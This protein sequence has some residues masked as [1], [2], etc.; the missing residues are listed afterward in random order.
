MKYNPKVKMSEVFHTIQ[1][2]GRF[3]GT[4]SIFVR[5]SLC[6]LRCRWCDTPYTSW[7]PEFELTTVDDVVEQV[8]NIAPKCRHVVIT[9]GEPFAQKKALQWLCDRLQREQY[10]VTIETAAIVWQYLYCSLL[11]MSPKL[12]TST[13][14]GTPQEKNH[15]KHRLNHD[16]I[17]QML[18]YYDCQ[19]KFVADSPTDVD[20]IKQLQKETRIPN[21]RIMLMPQGRSRDELCEREKWV[22]DVC[23]HEGWVY[24]PRAHIDIY[25]NQRGV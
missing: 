10:H 3:T 1:G 14:Y 25:G 16:V 11:S 15:E 8:V 12:S 17:K 2:E 7:D 22:V 21:D 24:T 13:P 5:F 20:E 23:K 19:V 9:G 6:P 4:P 18:N